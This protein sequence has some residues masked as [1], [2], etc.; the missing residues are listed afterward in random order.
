M[1]SDSKQKDSKQKGNFDTNR[2]PLSCIGP[3]QLIL[4]YR[5]LVQSERCCFGEDRKDTG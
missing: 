1:S 3:S 2:S 5:D 4:A